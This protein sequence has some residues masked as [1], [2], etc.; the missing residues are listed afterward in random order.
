MKGLQP[1]CA[2][3]KA[4]RAEFLRLIRPQ[5]KRCSSGGLGVDRRGGRRVSDQQMC[6]SNFP[7][8]CGAASPVG[9]IELGSDADDIRIAS[10]AGQPCH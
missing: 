4:K 5:E 1:Q 10:K 7:T 2:P 8:L 9:Q 6:S 3:R